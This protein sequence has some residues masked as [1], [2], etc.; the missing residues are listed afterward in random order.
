MFVFRADKTRLIMTQREPVTSGSV[1]VY[2][3]RFEFSADW[4]GLTRTAVFRAGTESRSVVLSVDG[5]CTIPWEVLATHG[6]RLTAG[7]YGTRGGDVVLPTVWTGL[8]TILE[9]AAPGEESRPPT[10]DVWEQA[11]GLKGD[12]LA[13]DG[14]NLSL[15][16]GDKPLSVVRLAGSGWPEIATDAEVGEMLEEVFGPAEA[17]DNVAT[18]EEIG[19]MLDEI[20]GFHE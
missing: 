6:Q 14:I 16:S 13:Y 7:V 19:E 8:G 10:P 4:D 9:G 12:S 17:P 3:V 11:L 18:D 5:L 15:M 1:N 2:Q 20:F